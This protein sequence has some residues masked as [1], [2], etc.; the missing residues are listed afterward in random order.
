MTLLELAVIVLVVAGWLATPCLCL[1]AYREWR[2]RTRQELTRT[3][4][5]FGLASLAITFQNWLILLCT[6][7]ISWARPRSGFGAYLDSAI[8]AKGETLPLISLLLFVLAVVLALAFKRSA[9]I[10]A[11]A[12]ADI[13]VVLLTLGLAFSPS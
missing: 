6:L 5:A 13:W 2:K 4:S 10:E 7:A 9:R 1:L 11:V 3:R 8:S 12:A